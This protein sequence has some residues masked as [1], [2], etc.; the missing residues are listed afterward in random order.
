M[1]VGHEVPS[2]PERLKA[3]V[4][5]RREGKPTP[6]MV[7]DAIEA[8][9]TGVLVKED[10]GTSGGAGAGAGATAGPETHSGGASG[11]QQYTS[12][13]QGGDWVYSGGA[14]TARS[15]AGSVY[16]TGGLSALPPRPR[17]HSG[18]PLTSQQRAA[19]IAAD[20]FAR[21]AAARSVMRQQS[22]AHRQRGIQCVHTPASLYCNS[23]SL[24]PQQNAMALAPPA[25]PW[26]PWELH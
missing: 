10:V 19:A 23:P 18:G 22:R 9:R 3:K 14:N 12:V 13:E 4:E 21:A 11:G 26:Q 8:E 6:R 20:S 25:L 7:S 1:R 5:A 16:S 17:K 15:G 24:S 2:V